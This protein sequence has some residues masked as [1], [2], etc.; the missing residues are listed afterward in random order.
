VSV[1]KNRLEELRTALGISRK[2]FAAKLGVCERTVYRWETGETAIPR[3]HWALL[4]DLLG[5]SVAYLLGFENGNGGN[6]EQRAS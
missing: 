5:V 1:P 2:D 4:S 6:G 3:K